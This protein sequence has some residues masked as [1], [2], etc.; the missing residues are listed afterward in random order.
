[1]ITQSAV[2]NGLENQGQVD[3]C[4]S[5]IP[6][7]QTFAAGSVLFLVNQHFTLGQSF[8]IEWRRVPSAIICERLAVM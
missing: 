2:A 4:A 3:A 5:E 8:S 6:N 1:M 7:E